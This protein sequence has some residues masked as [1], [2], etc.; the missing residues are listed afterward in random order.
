M[1]FGVGGAT[2]HPTLMCRPAPLSRMHS[3]A[4]PL[5]QLKIHFK[6]DSFSRLGVDFFFWK[7]TLYTEHFYIWNFVDVFIR[8]D[9]L[10]ER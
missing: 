2:C 10:H 3:G 1:K 9:T 4:T 8:L 6:N 7:I 5:K